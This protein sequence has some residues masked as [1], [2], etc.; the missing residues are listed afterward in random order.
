M[1]NVVY[2]LLIK[3]GIPFKAS[4]KDFLISCLNPEHDDNNPSCR[5]DKTTGIFHCFSCGF[6]GNLFKHFGIITS[7][8]SIRIQKLKEKLKDLNINFNGVDFPYNQIPYNKKFRGIS[9]KTLK[10]FGAFYTTEKEELNDRIF[11][12]ITDIRG[13]ISAFIGRHTMSM[14]NPRYLVYPTHSKLPVFPEVLKEPNKSLVLVEGLFDFLNLYDNGLTNV[15]C[16]FGTSTLFKDTALKMLPF[17]TQG[18]T[19]VFIMYDGDT[20]GQEATQKLKPLLEEAEF[21]VDTIQLE[22][23]RDPGDLSTEEIQSI[24]EW[25]NENSNN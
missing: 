6:R 12:P 24:K 22:E 10:E 23:D 8:N 13:K 16:T 11:F 15:A 2:D 9:V 18:I 21:I 19:H 4:G 14:G 1:T 25:I 3:K 20:A 7:S 5:V 17:K